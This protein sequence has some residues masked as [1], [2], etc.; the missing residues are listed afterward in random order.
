MSENWTKRAYHV[1]RM[2]K[3][4]ILGI[5]PDF[6]LNF[7]G[8]NQKNIGLNKSISDFGSKRAFAKK[9]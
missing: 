7:Y 9:A 8:L 5:S 4:P 3:L 1:L 6:E 2:K